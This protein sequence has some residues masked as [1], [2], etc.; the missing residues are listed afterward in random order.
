MRRNMSRLGS[1]DI[2]LVPPSDNLIYG[3]A[4]CLPTHMDRE[5]LSELLEVAAPE[6][7]AISV[8][9]HFADDSDIAMAQSDP[10]DRPR[11]CNWTL[12]SNLF[13][14]KAGKLRSCRLQR[15][16][17]PTP[18]PHALRGLTTFEYHVSS[19]L[20]A[21]KLEEILAWMP[22]LHRFALSCT[23]FINDENLPASRVHES[24]RDVAIYEVGES[25]ST[26]LEYFD[27]HKL[28]NI[29]LPFQSTGELPTS[30]VVTAVTARSVGASIRRSGDF[31]A[32]LHFFL[33]PLYR[34][35]MLNTCLATITTLTVDEATWTSCTP[36]YPAA[37]RL[38]VLRV[39]LSGCVYGDG[40]I[41]GQDPPFGLFACGL[42]TALECP[43]LRVLEISAHSQTCETLSFGLQRPCICTRCRFSFFDIET[44][45][46]SSLKYEAQQLD[47]LRLHG[48]ESIDWS[49]E[50][51]WGALDSIARR[52][53]C[54]PL[55]AM[56]ASRVWDN[57]DRWTRHDFF[58]TLHDNV[59]RD[60]TANWL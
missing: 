7:S 51:A 38:Q 1:F 57:L 41:N 2:D 39:L 14:G 36:F 13:A 54:L 23:G 45:V 34:R 25:Q 33:P 43:R 35:E 40:S 20:T 37:P 21:A 4:L 9:N 47:I 49:P 56:R 46:R 31:L 52:V 10:A 44:F 24:L 50:A 18:L 5:R 6:L 29:H 30:D 48:I 42:E 17:L 16:V 59:Q 26:L 11:H 27:Q 8:Y 55:A 22:L 32:M 60:L 19:F 12:P 58:E 15:L 28:C 53:D 3:T